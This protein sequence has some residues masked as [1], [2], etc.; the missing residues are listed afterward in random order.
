MPP[1]ATAG[2]LKDP[3]LGGDRDVTVGGDAAPFDLEQ[4]GEVGVGLQYDRTLDRRRIKVAD[5]DVGSHPVADVAAFDHEEGAVGMP[6]LAWYPADER[7]RVGLLGPRGQR[8]RAPAIDAQ[9]PPRDEPGIPHEEPVRDPRLDG[10][11]AVTDPEGRTVDQGD[12]VVSGLVSGGAAGH[13]PRTGHGAA[14]AAQAGPSVGAQR[15]PRAGNPARPAQDVTP[16]AVKI[17]R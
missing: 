6:G 15:T 16:S 3:A 4:V 5:F 17:A 9:F 1:A 8:L 13:G 2:K 14:S 12:Q 11:R 7:R 10:P